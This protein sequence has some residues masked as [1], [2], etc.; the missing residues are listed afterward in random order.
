MPAVRGLPAFAGR[1][2]R[3]AN[4]MVT[5]GRCAS[6]NRNDCGQNFRSPEDGLIL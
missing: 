5:E 2:P 3:Q 1:Q 4:A 6:N